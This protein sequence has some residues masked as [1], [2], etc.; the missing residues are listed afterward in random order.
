MI[1]E[2]LLKKVIA[3]FS[4]MTEV[5]TAEITADSELIDDLEISSMDVLF[6][7]SSLEE[8]FHISVSEKEI[9]K[10]VTVGDV[11]QVIQELKNKLE[12]NNKNPQ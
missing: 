12:R 8:E 11:V 2:A 10:M 7:I 3:L 1:D 6:L 9:R 4:T 5:P